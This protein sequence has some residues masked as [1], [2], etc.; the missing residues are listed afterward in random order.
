L[1]VL[2]AVAIPAFTKYIRRSK[3]G[4]AKVN[5]AKMFDGVKNFYRENQK[6]SGNGEVETGMTP[7]LQMNC[8]DG[9][10]GRCVAVTDPSAPGEYP[11]A[12]WTEN[13]RWQALGFAVQ[14]PHSFHYNVKWN[15]TS[16]GCQFTAQ[17]F[18]DLDDDGLFS[19]FERAGTADRNGINAAAGMY[20][21]H[22]VE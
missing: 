12:W 6:C 5:V 16:Q 22:E 15:Q 9:E 1:G 10:S 14:E 13:P 17:A 4:E 2:S 20:I 11:T 7:P 18:G 21:E 3:T 19:T 8:N